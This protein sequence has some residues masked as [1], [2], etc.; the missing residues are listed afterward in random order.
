[1]NSSPEP[2]HKRQRPSWASE[3]LQVFRTTPPRVP[4][5]LT[6]GSLKLVN[7][8]EAQKQLLDAFVHLLSLPSESRTRLNTPFQI[9]AGAPGM[10]KT[11]LL[12]ELENCLSNTETSDSV[13]SSTLYFYVTYNDGYPTTA[14]D[15][16]NPEA[17]LVLRMI[18]FGYHIHTTDCDGRDF[19]HFLDEKIWEYGT[20]R[21]SQLKN[22]DVLA[23]AEGPVV[24]GID[25]F[26]YLVPATP[27]DAPIWD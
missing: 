22:T 27:T 24:L 8:P 1:M 5:R 20:D 15:V 14:F 13:P 12:L 18:F 10:G 3:L 4:S 6:D 19:Q 2:P 17:A 26:N 21:L 25:E 16:K 7:R 23:V 9:V 11:R